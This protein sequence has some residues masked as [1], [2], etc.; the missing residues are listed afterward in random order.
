MT[1]KPSFASRLR[2]FSAARRGLHN[3]AL[4]YRL[5]AAALTAGALALLYVI[6]IYAVLYGILEVWL[7]LR[8][9]AHATS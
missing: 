3:A 7:S 1:D 5:G 9:R 6:G 8:L 4:A 2:R